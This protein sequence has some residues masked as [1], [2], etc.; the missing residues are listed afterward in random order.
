MHRSLNSLGISD[1]QNVMLFE[2]C[3]TV[4]I[5]AKLEQYKDLYLPEP[6]R[7]WDEDEYKKRVYERAVIDELEMLARLNPEMDISDI[8]YEFIDELIGPFND[9]NTPIEVFEIIGVFIDTMEAVM[10]WLD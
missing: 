6:K 8:I 1:L 3:V 9:P 10:A 2:S 5:V 4:D 7:N